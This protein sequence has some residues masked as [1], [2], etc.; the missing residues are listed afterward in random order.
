MQRAITG[1]HR[2]EEGHWVADLSCGHGRHTRHAPPFVQRP[3]VEDER[4]RAARLGQPLDCVRCDRAELP[5]GFAA[6]RRTAD[7]DENTLPQA[8]RSRHDTKAGVWALIHLTKGSVEYRV[9]E[10]L[11]RVEVLGPEEPGVVLPEVPHQLAVVG[12]V[13]L[14]VEFWR[15]RD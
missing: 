7:F 6:Y 5:E 9:H 12:P 11:H 2:D 3:W 8:L 15:R 1:F 13:E 14:H 4:G 10:P